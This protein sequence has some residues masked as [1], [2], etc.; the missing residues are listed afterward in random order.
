MDKCLIRLGV[1]A[2]ETAGEQG[3]GQDRP[4]ALVQTP[5]S[6]VAS[7]IMMPLKLCPS[8]RKVKTPPTPP[9]SQDCCQLRLGVQSGGGR[10]AV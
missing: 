10:K 3:G 1:T 9:P 8:I 6:C 7:A 5:T 4:L 2:G